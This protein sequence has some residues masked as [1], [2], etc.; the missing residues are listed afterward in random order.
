MNKLFDGVFEENDEIYTVNFCPGKKVYGEELK[1]VDGKEFRSWNPYTSKL[2]A[3]IKKGLKTFVFS[4]ENEVLYLGAA[5]GTTISHLSDICT[6]GMLYCVE[7]SPKVVK[8]LIALSKIRK[9]IA[10]LFIDARKPYEIS[11]FL[12]KSD[13]LYQDIAQRD[14]TD[15]LLRNAKQFL[16][17]GSIAYYCLKARSISSSKSVKDICRKEEEFLLKNFQIVEKINLEPYEKEH[18]FYVLMKR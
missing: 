13:V 9:N 10:P 6:K 2:A 1:Q 7:F 18:V 16:M 17:K 5:S 11:Y 12:N 3:A 15:I 14:Q 8:E 4:D